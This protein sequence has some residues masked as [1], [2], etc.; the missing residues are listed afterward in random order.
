MV[1]SVSRAAAILR[2]LGEGKNR[3]TDISRS[4]GLNMSTTHRLL[5]TLER[6]G[7]VIQDPVSHQYLLGPVI[8][9]IS[10]NP[11]I[12]HQRLVVSAQGEMERLRNLT[13]ET[14]T[15]NIRLGAQRICLE[16]IESNDNIKFT[17]GRG[18]M[19]PLYAGSAGKVLL[20]ELPQKELELLLRNVDLRPIGPKTITDR[21]RLQKELGRIR[22]EGHAVSLG[23]KLAGGRAISV[24]IKGYVCPVSMTILGPEFRFGARYRGYIRE[25][26]R[27][28]AI[29]SR[30]IRSLAEA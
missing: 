2:I 26:K 24:P 29:I 12:A 25:L 11:F 4:L 16:E 28:A 10:S 23:E 14:V 7:F 5:K 21:S 19:A 18:S 6:D 27:S 9:Q 20:A 30:R 3:L 8:L 13:G 22:R 1:N 15:I 17:I